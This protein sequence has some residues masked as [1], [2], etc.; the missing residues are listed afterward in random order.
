VPIDAVPIDAVPIDAV[1]ITTP[2]SKAQPAKAKQVV[3]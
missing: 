3:A 1:P 2:H